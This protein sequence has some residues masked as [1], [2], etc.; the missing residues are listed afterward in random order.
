MFTSF[1]IVY[2]VVLCQFWLYW[3]EQCVNMVSSVCNMVLM[4]YR[5]R[6]RLHV[7]ILL[8]HFVVVLWSCSVDITVVLV[9]EM[10]ELSFTII[11][12]SIQL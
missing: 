2:M 9:G 1:V 5:P 10:C 11:E 3:L 8:T 7:I 12:H 6:D 4:S